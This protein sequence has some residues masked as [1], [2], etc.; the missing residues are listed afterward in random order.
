M[1]HSG[2]VNPYMTAYYAYVDLVLAQS[3]DRELPL[4]FR[5]GFSGVLSNTIVRDDHILLGAP[6]PWQLE[7]LRE[8]P[9][10]PLSKLLAVTR[11]SPEVL[12]ADRREIFDAETWAFVH[13]L[14]FGEERRRAEKLVRTRSS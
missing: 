9:L 14:M 12:E 6:I 11:R 3:I 13:F 1:D 5:H 4:W 2:T 8:R 7:I 10:L